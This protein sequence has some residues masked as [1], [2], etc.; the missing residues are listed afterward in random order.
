MTWTDDKKMTFEGHF[1]VPEKDDIIQN[2]KNTAIFA[3]TIVAP[4]GVP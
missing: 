3:V 2:I 4:T 1:F